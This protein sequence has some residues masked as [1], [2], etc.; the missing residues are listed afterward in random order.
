MQPI[1]QL[2]L[3]GKPITLA[4]RG[5]ALTFTDHSGREADQLDVT[6]VDHDNRIALPRPG[7]TLRASI[8][9]AGGALTD[10]GAF[11]VDNVQH[12]GPPDKIQIRAHSADLAGSW[13]EKR[14]QGWDDLTVEDI[15]VTIAFRH[16]VTPAFDPGLGAIE[17]EHI[18]Q[19]GESDL[20]FLTRLG[21]RVGGLFAVKDGRLLFKKRADG[22]AISGKALPTILIRR[23]DCESHR[24]QEQQRERYTG[25][26]AH[27]WDRDLGEKRE[28]FVGTP[29]HRRKLRAA[30]PNAVEADKAARA[31][32]QRL[33][34]AKAALTLSGL[35]GD[36]RYRA[37][38]PA[39]LADF[40]LEIQAQA[41]VLDT[42]TH[43]LDDG[44][45][46]VDLDCVTPG[47]DQS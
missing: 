15:L 20:H 12:G 37:E 41:W 24:Y 1:F 23:S 25:V 18:D 11:V 44:G 40:P 2:T 4:G 33:Q 42:A 10:L 45:W 35:V 21:E 36:A 32:W 13:T 38:T 47:S 39:V 43:R 29:G 31:E 6:V 8:G 22:R 46:L 26:V 17:I 7:V 9:W 28:L 30:Y 3:D 5:N 16:D 14:D 34:T 19:T 27:W